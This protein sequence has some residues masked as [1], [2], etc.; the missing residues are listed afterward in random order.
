MMK[1]TVLIGVP[2]GLDCIANARTISTVES[3]RRYGGISICYAPTPSVCLGRDMIVQQAERMNPRPTHL[4]FL[5]SDVVPLN[6]ILQPLLEADK[7]IVS[8]VCPMVDRGIKWNISL[9]RPFKGIPVEELPA[10]LFEVSLCGFAVVLIRYEVF[11]R[12]EW[13]YWKNIISRGSVDKGED[14]YFCEKATEC[15]YQIWCHPKAV[16]D[17]VRTTNLLGT[18]EEKL[19]IWEDRL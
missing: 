8:G 5:D 9:S 12:L 2:I 1:N 3:W 7:D 10:E 13:P 4:L 11:E 17:H 19:C 16:C 14:V 6:N 18:I 15:G